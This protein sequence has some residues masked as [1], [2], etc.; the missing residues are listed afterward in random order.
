MNN[1]DVKL[2]LLNPVPETFVFEIV[3]QDY[4]NVDCTL[5][6]QWLDELYE[7]LMMHDAEDEAPIISDHFK[8]I[9]HD[10]DF[11]YMHN[12]VIYYVQA[13]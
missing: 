10:K 11:A 7:L 4:F 8:G 2:K 1:F 5:K 13:S 6:P 9:A 3:V 12:E